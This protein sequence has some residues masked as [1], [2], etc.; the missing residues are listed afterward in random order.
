[1]D[2]D[3]PEIR[4]T[5]D[6]YGELPDYVR[7]NNLCIYK[8]GGEFVTIPLAKSKWN[9]YKDEMEKTMVNVDR[10]KSKNIPIDKRITNIGEYFHFQNSKE[11]AKVR[12]IELAEKQMKRW[13]KLSDKSSDT[14]SINF[15]N[16]NIDRIMMDAVDEL[17]KL[18]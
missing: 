8:G 6:P 1:M 17:D 4:H 5:Q 3:A 16:Q 13:K 11:A 2:A 7:R 15:T 18:N 9:N 10:L 12:V 14:E